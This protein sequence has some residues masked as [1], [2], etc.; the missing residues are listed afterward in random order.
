[1]KVLFIGSR[2]GQPLGMR[3][4]IERC[5]HEVY[6]VDPYPI[7]TQNH[8][9]N[10]WSFHTGGMFLDGRVQSHLEHEIGDQRRFDI[11]FIDNGELLRPAMVM[12]LKSR[13]RRVILFNRDNPFVGRDGFRW[14]NVLKA[15]PLYDLYVTPRETTVRDAR[16]HGAR[17]VLQV[18][19]FADEILHQPRLPTEDEIARFGSPVSFVGTWFPERG[20]FMHVLIDRGVPLRIIGHKW[21]R[22]KNWKK[23]KP[24]VTSGYLSPKDYCGALLSCDIAIA[25]LSK[26]NRDVSTSRSMEIPAMGK[27]LCAERTAEHQRLYKE[28]EEAYFWSSAQECADICLRLLADPSHI[29]QVAQAGRVAAMNNNN[30]SEPMMEKILYAAEA[31]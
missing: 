21:D 10:R 28:G 17:H 27:L 19:F 29:A 9:L 1:M 8:H 3:K 13:A 30:W 25:M 4:A 31:L 24:H 18:N 2:G 22:A 5:G 11:A 6:H 7:V 20:S 23:L 26:G 12:F 16:T 14:R 15:L